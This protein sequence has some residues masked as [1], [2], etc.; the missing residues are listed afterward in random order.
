MCAVIRAEK[1]TPLRRPQK[2][3]TGREEKKWSARAGENAEE[4]GERR[5]RRIGVEKSL[6]ARST[7]RGAKKVIFSTK[8]L[9]RLRAI[10]Y[11][12]K[13][14]AAVPALFKKFL[15]PHSF[16]LLNELPDGF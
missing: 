3:P 5:E 9:F 16:F 15:A 4:K 8:Q 14:C 1:F 6:A 10:D 11:K 7:W 12:T 2:W 13:H